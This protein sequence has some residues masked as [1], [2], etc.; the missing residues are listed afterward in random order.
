VPDLVL[1]IEPKRKEHTMRIFIAGASGAI[2][3]HLVPLLVGSGHEVVATTRS[4]RKAPDLRALGAQPVILDVLDAE[5]VGRV[6]SE[7]APEVIVH[8]ATALADTGTN[9]RNFDKA[10]AQTNRLRTAGTDN[11][12]AAARAVDVKKFVAQSY[13]GWPY[14]REGGPVKTEDDP[15]DPRPPSDATES[16][17]AIRQL[18]E[19]VV[20][21][22]WLE[23]IA[24]R[25][26]GFYGPGTSLAHGGEAEEAIR[27]RKFPI[28][29]SGAGLWSFA[30]IED[31]ARATLAAIERGRRGIYNIVDDEPAPVSEWLPYLAREVGAKPPRHVPLWL[32]KL[33]TG[34]QLVSMMTETR[35][36]SNAKAK[37]ELGWQPLYPSWREGFV[38]GFGES[39]VKHLRTA[40]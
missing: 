18:E 2:G 10:F 14:A 19:R 38:S 1:G 32:G 5:A 33:L 17:A 39:E 22:E 26:G 8:Q 13:G 12:L 40:A 34:E 11:L 3:K 25:Y 30:Q 21:A 9:L 27:K 35:G 37:R 6:V 28:I 24:L 23:G 36:A 29:G 4:E 15:L 16:L 31:T 7:A 20:G